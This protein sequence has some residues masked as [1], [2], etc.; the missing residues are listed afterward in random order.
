MCVCVCVCVCV[1][2]AE[3]EV[4]GN[5]GLLHSRYVDTL[6]QETEKYMAYILL[7]IY[8]EQGRGREGGRGR[9]RRREGEKGE[10]VNLLL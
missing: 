2:L 3:E 10:R 7:I 6:L 1:H 9:E 5:K 8:H 4:K